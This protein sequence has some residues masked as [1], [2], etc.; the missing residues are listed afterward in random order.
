MAAANLAAIP[1]P[2]C[3]GK[4]K[5][6]IGLAP[7]RDKGYNKHM[8][9]FESEKAICETLGKVGRESMTEEKIIAFVK[10]YGIPWWIEPTEKIVEACPIRLRPSNK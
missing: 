2:E 7:S 1:L 4:K 8:D 5:K 10:L 6:R 9:R 3:Q